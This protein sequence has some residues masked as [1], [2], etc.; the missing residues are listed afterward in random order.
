MKNKISSNSLA[1]P[2]PNLETV[3]PDSI[4]NSRNCLPK[5][6]AVPTPSTT[7]VSNYFQSMR[8]WQNPRV[9][10]HSSRRELRPDAFDSSIRLLIRRQSTIFFLTPANFVFSRELAPLFSEPFLHF[11]PCVA[12][13]FP[14]LFRT[15]S[16]HVPPPPHCAPPT[17]EATAMTRPPSPLASAVAAVLAWPTGA[18]TTPAPRPGLRPSPLPPARATPSSS[19]PMATIGEKVG[20]DGVFF[21]NNP[22]NI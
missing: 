15:L 14:S 19:L 8:R 7:P 5:F 4:H 12:A 22:C 9:P 18:H 3:S 20:E 16:P 17:A 1:E 6:G 21:Q 2:F 11:S 10:L 13:Q